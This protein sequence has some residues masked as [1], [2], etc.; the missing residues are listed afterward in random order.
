MTSKETIDILVRI[1]NRQIE[2]LRKG[3]I[4]DINAPVGV[5]ASYV[6][7][8]DAAANKGYLEQVDRCYRLTDK[9][10]DLMNKIER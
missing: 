1:T 7:A 4:D 6:S 5:A 9:G 10:L 8:A 3:F 2:L